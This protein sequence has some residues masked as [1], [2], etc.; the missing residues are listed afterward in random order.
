MAAAADHFHGILKTSGR[1]DGCA[2]L[3]V[4]HH[5]DVEGSLQTLLDV[6]ALRGLDIL[7]V[8][9][10]KGGGDALHGLTELFRILL[11]HLNIK[12]VDAAV[13]LEE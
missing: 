8:D 9:A 5:G 11:G 13:D 2:V 4:V 1:D 3:V 7:Q 10:T 12:Y 6:E